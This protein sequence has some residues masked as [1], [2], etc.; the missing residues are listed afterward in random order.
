MKNRFIFLL[1]LIFA[2]AAGFGV[3]K[4]MGDLK[5]AYTSSGNFTPVA[6]AKKKIPARIV[7]GEDM[8]EMK[9]MPA[10]YIPAGAVTGKKDAVGKLSRTDI[11][12]GE[13]LLQNK[14]LDRNS[15]GAGLSSKVEPGKRAI[16]IPV[17]NVTALHGLVNTGDRVDIIV[18]FTP[19]GERGSVSAGIVQNVPVL[20]VNASLE[21]STQPKDE[22][23]TVTVMVEPRDAQKIALA[24]QQGSVQL[25]LRSPS[26]NS[27]NPV[28]PVNLQKLLE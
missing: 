1:A 2:L 20:A 11:Y 9:E 3:Y 5:M 10:A 4:Y 24:I 27:K 23:K 25:V 13:L 17:N 8:I 14:L 21:T 18:T 22:P 7:I 28:N 6:V 16:S 26:D 19:P 15:A 12:P